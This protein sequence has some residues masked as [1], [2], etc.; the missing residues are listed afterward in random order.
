MAG[1]LIPASAVAD[2][3]PALPSAPPKLGGGAKSKN[4]M[5]RMKAKAKKITDAGVTETQNGF[6]GIEKENGGDDD[7]VA[8]CI[9]SQ[10]LQLVN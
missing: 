8:V 3:D 5:R 1:N 2:G 10:R 9:V 6:N 4:Q 7:D